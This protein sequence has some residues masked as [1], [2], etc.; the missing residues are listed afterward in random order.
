MALVKCHECEKEISDEAKQ[1]PHCGAKPEKKTSLGSWVLAGIVLFLVVTCVYD[2]RERRMKAEQAE[3]ERLAKMTPQQRA[4]EAAAKAKSE[5]LYDARVTC[6]FALEKSLHDPASAKL[7]STYSW[8]AEERKDGTILVQ[9]SGRAK[10]AFGAYIHGTW[11]CVT[12]KGRLLSLNQ[13][14]P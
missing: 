9:P 2:G 8:Y 4:A 13:I 12:K 1:C 5:R 11:N 6:Q 3:A 7:D 14:R 10:N